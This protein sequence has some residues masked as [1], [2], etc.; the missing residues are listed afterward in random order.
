MAEDD[1][2]SSFANDRLDW[3]LLK[4]FRDV[5]RAGAF[6]QA[7]LEQGI[8]INTL[9]SRVDRVEHMAGRPLLHRSI[10]GVAITAEGQ[11]LLDVVDAMAAQLLTAP[12]RTN[13]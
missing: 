4:A 8:S 9:R 10:T 13:L 5:A 3:S 2:L 11:L 1:W 7:A 12:A 6:R